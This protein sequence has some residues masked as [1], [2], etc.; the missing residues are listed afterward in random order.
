MISYAQ[1]LAEEIMLRTNTQQPKG[2]VRVID[3]RVRSQPITTI[4]AQEIREV[5]V[6]HQEEQ[7]TTKPKQNIIIKLD[8]AVRN[9]KRQAGSIGDNQHSAI[10]KLFTG[11]KRL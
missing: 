7:V 9:F 11:K 8:N 6:Q 10:S 2:K 4:P 1:R 5:V 3:D